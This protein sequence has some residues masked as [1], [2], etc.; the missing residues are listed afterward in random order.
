MYY[1]DDISITIIEANGISAAAAFERTLF[2]VF[3]APGS[4]PLLAAL[5]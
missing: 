4:H 2:G 1:I 5:T 3:G